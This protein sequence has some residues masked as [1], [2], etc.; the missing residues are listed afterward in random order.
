MACHFHPP[1]QSPYYKKCDMCK[2]VMNSKI[3]D[4]NHKDSP[5]KQW[6]LLTHRDCS[7]R[8]PWKMRVV[9]I[10]DDEREEIV[11]YVSTCGSKAVK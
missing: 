2:L 9:T 8:C 10:Y 11:T 1:V 5:C 7:R 6:Y 3:Y 4:I